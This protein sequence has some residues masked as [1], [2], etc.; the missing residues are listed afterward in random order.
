[1]VLCFDL[2]NLELFDSLFAFDADGAVISRG[3][4]SL[5][6]QER[7]ELCCGRGRRQSWRRME[8]CSDPIQAS[9][10]TFSRCEIVLSCLRQTATP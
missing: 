2:S 5:L 6:E 1:M 4:P 7:L 8:S 9:L 10:A 3:R